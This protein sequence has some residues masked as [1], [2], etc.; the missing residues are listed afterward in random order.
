MTKEIDNII[1][2]LHGV[3]KEMEADCPLEDIIP[4]MAGRLSASKILL[5]YIEKLNNK[6][7][8]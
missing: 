7:P 2:D 8:L 6:Q 5:R 1:N 3:V 4:Y